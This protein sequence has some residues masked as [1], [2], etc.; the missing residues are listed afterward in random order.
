MGDPSHLLA[1]LASWLPWD[2]I[3]AALAPKFARRERPAQGERLHDLFAER[4]VK[5]GAV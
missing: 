4:E 2:R 5:R 3:E 1:V